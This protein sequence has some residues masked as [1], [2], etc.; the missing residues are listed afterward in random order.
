MEREQKAD[1]LFRRVA[2]SSDR[3]L[4]HAILVGVAGGVVGVL[5]R[6]SLQGVYGASP[7][8]ML[9]LP[10]I[11]MA[12]LWA[13][14]TAGFTALVM[15]VISAWAFTTLPGLFA[16]DPL[17]GV[18]NTVT[19]SI[20]SIFGIILASSLRRTLRS[21]DRSLT[22][23]RQSASAIDE[24][25]ARFR[26]VSEDAPVM[27]WMS[28]EQGACVYL[29]KAQRSFWG[30]PDDLSAF[31]WG[32]TLHPE[33]AERVFGVAME[34]ATAGQG[35]QV[36]ARY[37][38]HDGQWRILVTEAQPRFDSDGRYFGMIGVNMDVTEA[39]MVEDALRENEA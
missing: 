16:L 36:E 2:L 37:R 31:D 17:Q 25:E 11:L 34:A 35:F 23:L 24:G 5:I 22:D 32:A 4:T 30:A 18:V 10:G 1:R 12:A 21:L 13:G 26:L 33:D 20:T 27:L 14:R 38:R 6:L 19:F 39:R 8:L 29:N 15:A 3:G 9:Y 7:G 28:D